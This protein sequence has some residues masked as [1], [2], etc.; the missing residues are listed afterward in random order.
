MLEGADPPVRFD[1]GRMHNQSDPPPDDKTT[2][3]FCG[4]QLFPVEAMPVR[5]NGETKVRGKYCCKQGQVHLDPIRNAVPWLTKLWH[6]LPGSNEWPIAQTL[7][8]FSRQLNDGLAMA[9]H[10]VR[11]K[12]MPGSAFE[13]TVVIQG[14]RYEYFGP[15]LPEHGNAPMHAQ[16]YVNDPNN[17]GEHDYLKLRQGG[18]YVPAQTSKVQRER[19]YKLM[20]KLA[21]DVAAA[22]PYAK[23]FKS[24]FESNQA[25]AAQTNI[26][27]NA[28]A[29][30]TDTT[31]GQQA[32]ARTYNPVDA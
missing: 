22:N 20:E 24:A 5:L 28:R 26:V 1:V 14:K 21:T 16:L 3:V 8:T 17:N 30:P 23:D 11:K 2:C 27:I 12:K 25:H 15:L 19:L 6:T 9:S 32:H 29:R 7:R 4:A 31:T 18:L 13:P 10:F